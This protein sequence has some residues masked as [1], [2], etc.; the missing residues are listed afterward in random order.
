MEGHGFGIDGS[1]GF[2]SSLWSMLNEG[3]VW[4]V[5]RSGLVLRKEGTLFIV[6]DR[7]PW[8]P[9]MPWTEAEWLELQADEIRDLTTM[10]AGIGVTVQEIEL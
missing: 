2:A 5:P 3:G 6:Q 10:F 1:R 7:M 9:V 4:A 8:I